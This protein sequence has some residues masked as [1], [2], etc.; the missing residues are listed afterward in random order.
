MIIYSSFLLDL[1]SSNS[2]CSPSL[3]QTLEG[4]PPATRRSSPPQGTIDRHHSRLAVHSSAQICLGRRSQWQYLCREIP[5]TPSREEQL[6]TLRY[7]APAGYL[8]FGLAHMHPRL[9]VFHCHDIHIDN[10][11]NALARDQLI[12]DIESAA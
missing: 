4:T 6:E 12:S 3:S 10:A 1:S 7:I 9:K 11:Q 8:S 2:V 5:L